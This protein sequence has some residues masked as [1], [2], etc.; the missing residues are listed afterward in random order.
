MTQNAA[1]NARVSID[2]SPRDDYGRANFDNRHAFVTSVNFA[3]F[4]GF[5]TGAI[6]RYYSGYPINETIGTDVNGDRDNIDRPVRGVHDLTMPILSEVDGNGRAVRNGID[7]NSLTLVDLQ[8]Q[9][10]FRMQ[11]RQSLGLFAEIYNLFN[12]ENLGNPTGNRNN[13][14]FMVP[15]EAGSMRSA[16]LGI[17]YTF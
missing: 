10:V 11:Q 7:G 12:K 13:R 4:G 9:Y 2:P 17:R 5:T 1:L 15:V 3:P 14:N 8:L 6:V 16:Q